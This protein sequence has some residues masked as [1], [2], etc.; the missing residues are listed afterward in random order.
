[1]TLIHP[2]FFSPIIQYVL[3][4]KSQSIIF[5]IKDNFQKQTFRNRCHIYSAQGN[6]ML[7][8][9]VVHQRGIKQKTTDV[10]IDYKDSWNKLH[11]KSLQSAYSSSPFYE[12]YVD[13][14]T[15]VLNS[16][17][18]FLQDLNLA[19]HDFIMDALQLELPTSFS[20]KYIV[21]Y[22]GYDGRSLVLAK[23][24]KQYPLSR[25]I[26]VF[27]QSHGFVPNLS[28]LDL[29]FMEGPNALNYLESQHLELPC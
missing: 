3:V 26:Q 27:E 13:D 8:V 10:K 25:Y 28:I 18:S 17:F 7:N 5:E 19:C 14:L 16:N 21:E 23:P 12:F 20:K 29:L 1:M 2:G 15:K 24:E 11:L 22:Q 6:L 4:A 9:P